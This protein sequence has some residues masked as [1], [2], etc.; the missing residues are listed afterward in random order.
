MK[1]RNSNSCNGCLCK[2]CVSHWY[3]INNHC[4]CC[5]ICEKGDMYTFYCNKHKDAKERE[6]KK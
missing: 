3:Q 6:D 1:I 2:N 5:D 4:R